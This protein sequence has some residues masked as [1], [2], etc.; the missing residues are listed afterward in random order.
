MLRISGLTFP[1]DNDLKH[2]AYENTGGQLSEQ[3][4]EG[5]GVAQPESGPEPNTEALFI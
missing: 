3:L 4:S 2:T 1:K 5:P